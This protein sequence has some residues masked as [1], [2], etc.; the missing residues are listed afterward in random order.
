MLGLPD[1]TG[2]RLNGGRPGA[3]EGPAA[4]RTALSRYGVAI[5][6]G[7]VW[8]TLFDAGDVEP[9]PGVTERALLET[10]SR[11]EQATSA[12]L[13]A[14]MFPIAVG[15]GHDLTLPFAGRV[16]KHAAG[17]DPSHAKEV[18]YFD[19][20]LDVR[21]T[22]G[23]GM[24]FRK[25][26]EAHGVSALTII[27][28]DEF[29]NSAEH[30][31]WFRSHG[32]TFATQPPRPSAKTIRTVSFDLDCLDSGFAPGVSALNPCGL[33]MA[34]VDP[35]IRLLGADH[36]VRAFD[37]MELSPPYDVDGRTARIAARLFLSFLRG[38][39]ERTR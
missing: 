33:S 23:S 36:S 32:G 21:E 14:G 28:F 8:P 39:S 16:L 15:G 17:S 9:V 30:V 3:S 2:V 10:H 31:G 24:P 1:D 5:P 6:D 35:M 22:V 20:H 12:I 13:S 37:I 29:A 18:V 25:L 26:V 11:I 27:G 38:F 7:A 19:A 4:F 34:T